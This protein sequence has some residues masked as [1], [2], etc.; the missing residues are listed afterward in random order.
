[1]FVCIFILAFIQFPYFV[2]DIVLSFVSNSV[3]TLCYYSIGHLLKEIL[4]KEKN[5]VY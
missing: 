1:M 2:D 3:T 5:A 4:L